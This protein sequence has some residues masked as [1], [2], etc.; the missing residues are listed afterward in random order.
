MEDGKQMD[1][2][3]TDSADLGKAMPKPEEEG[4][5]KARSKPVSTIEPQKVS[6]VGNIKSIF[7]QGSRLRLK[8]SDL[9]KC[10]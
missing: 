8:T 2:C 5:A 1:K 9:M 6:K 3:Y 7:R 4:D 10:L